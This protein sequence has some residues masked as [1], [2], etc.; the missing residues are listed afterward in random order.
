LGWKRVTRHR[1]DRPAS[2]LAPGYGKCALRNAFVVA[3]GDRH[4]HQVIRVM[5][6][7]FTRLVEDSFPE[8][9][10][11][12]KPGRR[13]AFQPMRQ[14][15]GG[16][17]GYTVGRDHAGANRIEVN[18]I[19]DLPIALAA[20]DPAGANIADVFLENPTGGSRGDGPDMGGPGASHLGP[21]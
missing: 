15:T 14:T 5:G 16:E 11:W 6:P 4:A 12:V 9:I 10:G 2:T 8:K 19:A 20:A 21:V 17:L 3:S 1:K 18:V 13:R 7:W